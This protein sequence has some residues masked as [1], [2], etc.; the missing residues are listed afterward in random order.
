MAPGSRARKWFP[1]CSVAP[2]MTK[3]L[4]P[5]SRVTEA[6]NPQKHICYHSTPLLLL[7][8]HSGS[9]R[10]LRIR[11]T[12]SSDT[13]KSSS[14]CS[15]FKAFWGRISE[16]LGRLWIQS[17]AEWVFEADADEAT[18]EFVPTRFPH[19][20]SKSCWKLE[21]NKGRGPIARTMGRESDWAY[22]T[23]ILA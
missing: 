22:G 13:S 2:N 1:A 3:K 20:F 7:R 12:G 21:W 18:E 8:P 5:L 10:S 6:S 16:I 17:C 9:S 11:P 15:E 4:L 14:L 19:K 23:I